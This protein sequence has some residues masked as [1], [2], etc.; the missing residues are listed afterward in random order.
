MDALGTLHV[1]IEIAHLGEHDVLLTVKI[2][3]D[4]ATLIV[5]MDYNQIILVLLRI[6]CIEEV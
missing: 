2:L 1:T 4:S 6:L 3:H 5:D